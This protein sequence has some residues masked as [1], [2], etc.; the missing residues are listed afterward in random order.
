ME[1]DA[2]IG[3][4]FVELQ[5]GKPGPA[6]GATPD[7]GLSSSRFRI[8]TFPVLVARYQH[9]GEPLHPHPRCTEKVKM[10]LIMSNLILYLREI[11]RRFTG[12]R[13]WRVPRALGVRACGDA[14]GSRLGSAP[15]R[16]LPAP[17]ARSGRLYRPPRAAGPWSARCCGRTSRAARHAGRGGRRFLV[18][19]GKGPLLAPAH[20]ASMSWS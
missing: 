4:H 10:W 9:G 6:T 11:Y 5:G 2:D 19:L 16:T 14:S 15:P 3:M 13:R 12:S 18:I 7:H 20:A 8:R 17:P 1:W